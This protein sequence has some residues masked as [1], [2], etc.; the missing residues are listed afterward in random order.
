MDRE[1]RIS[2]LGL[3][4]WFICAIFFTYEFLLR[5]ILGT[6]Q[7]EITQALDLTAMSFA[8]LS[9]TS[10]QI[11]YGVMQ[12]PVGFIVDRFGL[13]LS[14]TLAAGIC[15][16]SV[17]GFSA[18]HTFH[19]A[20]YMRVLMG[21]G[22]AFGFVCLLACVYDWLPQKNIAFFIGLSQ[23]IGTLGPM[24]AAGP[25]NSIATQST[26][27]WRSVMSGLGFIGLMITLLIVLFVKNNR[28]PSPSMTILESPRPMVSRLISLVK[29]SQVWFIALYSG[30][31][32]FVIEYLSENSGKDFLMMK[33]FSSSVSSYM[34]TLSWLGFAISCPLVGFISDRL[35]NRTSMMKVT[36]VVCLIAV[37]VIFYAPG[38]ALIFDMTFLALGFGTAGQSIGF[39]IMAEQCN[40]N[41]LAAGLGLNN[42]MMFFFG[43]LFAPLIGTVL[44]HLAQGAMP[45]ISDYHH[46]F[47]IIILMVTFGCLL[48]FF[49]IEET[50]CKSTKQFTKLTRSDVHE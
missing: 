21:L 23:F 14:L 25:V 45:S 12:I 40:Y 24:M 34:I 5:T 20:L 47:V 31:T 7:S 50:F 37:L 33:G 17:F 11:I 22:S 43:S 19:Y 32:Y 6:F 1:N 35:Q 8:L 3:L 13:K 4:I 41:Y 38:N 48:S 2:Y 44:N 26:L 42:A 18:A 36:A 30:S 27:S 28:Q 9:S 46:A 39:A 29:Q 16:A 49:L 10:Y 15:V